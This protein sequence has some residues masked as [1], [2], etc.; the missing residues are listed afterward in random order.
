MKTYPRI[1]FL[2]LIAILCWGLFDQNQ[3][4]SAEPEAARTKSKLFSNG[5]FVPCEKQI[6]IKAVSV[7][8]RDTDLKSGD[9]IKFFVKLESPCYFYLI[10][11]SSQGDVSV[12]YPFRFTQLD[13]QDTRFGKQYIPAGNQ[14]F[15]LDEHTGREKFFLL[16][17]T[18][19]LLDLETLVNQYESADKTKKS[20]Q[21]D[22]IIFRDSQTEKTSSQI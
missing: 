3:S 9:R 21:A 15:E 17:S 4:R 12:L 1:F 13:G 19:R 16:A 7:I 14:W 22:K 2:S 10:Y 5:H 8:T 6:P 20:G 18:N 11:Q